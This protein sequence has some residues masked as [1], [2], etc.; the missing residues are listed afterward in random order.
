MQ[1]V[2]EDLSSREMTVA[3][4]ATKTIEPLET[5]GNALKVPESRLVAVHGPELLINVGKGAEF[6]RLRWRTLLRFAREGSIPPRHSVCKKRRKWRVLVSELDGW[7]RS[8][9]NSSCDRCQNS[10]RK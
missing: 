1:G 9:V 8:Q 4:G 5:Q 7:M 10:R 3:S 2:I 6:V